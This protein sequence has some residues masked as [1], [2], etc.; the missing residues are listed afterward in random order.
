MKSIWLWMKMDYMRVTTA[1][2][3]I[4]NGKTPK[5]VPT[6]IYIILAPFGIALLPVAIVVSK[7]MIYRFNQQLDKYLAKLEEV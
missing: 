2:Y 1:W 6:I 3:F 4:F 5:W 7:C